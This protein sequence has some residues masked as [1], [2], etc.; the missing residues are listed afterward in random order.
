MIY[1]HRLEIWPGFV[2]SVSEES[3]GLMLCCDVSH[4]VLQSTTALE[5][6]T[7]TVLNAGKKQGGGNNGGFR[8][9]VQ[10]TMLGEVVLTR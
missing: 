6:M 7:D 3:D 8:A 9:A 1:F 10:K 5:V 4:R 2:T